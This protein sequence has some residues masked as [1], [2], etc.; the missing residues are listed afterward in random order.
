MKNEFLWY[1][2]SVRCAYS[3]SAAF[4]VAAKVQVDAMATL[5]FE[6]LRVCSNFT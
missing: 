6:F 5:K 2:L 1:V 3:N 4:R